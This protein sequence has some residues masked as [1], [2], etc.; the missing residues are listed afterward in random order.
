VRAD[1]LDTVVWDHIT[2][3]LADPQL[4]RA[5]IDK[6]LDSARTND[7]AARQRTQLA[8]ALA[9]AST[10][11]TRMIEAFGEQVITLDELRARMPDGFVALFDRSRP[12]SRLLVWGHT[13]WASSSRAVATR[14]FGGESA[15]SS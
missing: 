9:K 5:E 4:I 14:S 2:R 8:T 12:W 13:A 15:A 11:I 7:P 10:G 3:M 6:R 1:Y